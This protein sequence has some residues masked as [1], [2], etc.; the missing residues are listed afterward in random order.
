M[1]GGSVQVDGGPRK[2]AEGR[3][4]LP[5]HHQNLSNSG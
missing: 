1:G 2:G 5:E 3:G 4:F